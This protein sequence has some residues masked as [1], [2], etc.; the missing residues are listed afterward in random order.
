MLSGR[1]SRRIEGW[2]HD[3]ARTARIGGRRVWRGTA[4]PLNER[5]PPARLARQL[6]WR[7]FDEHFGTHCS[8][9]TG[10][11]AIS[12]RLTVSGWVENPYWQCLSGM[13]FLRHE[14][15]VS[16]SAMSRWRSRVGR[17][18]GEELSRETV[19]T[20]PR[21]GAVKPSELRRANADTTARRKHVRFPTDPR[22]CWRSR[23]RQRLAK[24]AR[25]EGVRLRQSRGGFAGQ[26]PA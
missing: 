24:A 23:M 25:R 11:P 15:P 17:A 5:R 3:P 2:S 4:N 20:G 1:F 16:P 9:R 12:T 14:P 13:E 26:D 18:G 19:E 7:S 6:D 10:R 21:L 8:E 22:L